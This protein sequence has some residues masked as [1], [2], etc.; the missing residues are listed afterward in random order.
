MIQTGDKQIGP[1]HERCQGDDENVEFRAEKQ[2]SHF[3][4]CKKDGV[5]Q[6]SPEATRTTSRAE[7]RVFWRCRAEQLRVRGWMDVGRRSLFFGCLVTGHSS[8]VDLDFWADEGDQLA[9][10]LQPSEVGFANGF[11]IWP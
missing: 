4:F 11:N 2:R 5:R 10:S 3:D 6:A 9:G 1:Q 7:N 8:D